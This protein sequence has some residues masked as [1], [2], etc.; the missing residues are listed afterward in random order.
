MFL[1]T[2]ML[3]ITWTTNPNADTSESSSRW[4]KVCAFGRSCKKS[5]AIDVKKLASMPTNAAQKRYITRTQP[6]VTPGASSSWD[7]ISTIFERTCLSS[8][9]LAPNYSIQITIEAY[10]LRKRGRIRREDKYIAQGEQREMILLPGGGAGLRG[11]GGGNEGRSRANAC[12]GPR[13]Q[14]GVLVILPLGRPM[15]RRSG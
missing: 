5:T 4:A 13:R 3:R 10:T 8:L 14:A 11:R 9:S 12:R 1:T 15:G 6:R 7:V 2:T